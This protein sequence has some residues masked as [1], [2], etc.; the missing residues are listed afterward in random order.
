MKKIKINIYHIISNTFNFR[1]VTNREEYWT[2]LLFYLLIKF[3]MAII[4]GMISRYQIVYQ[5]YPLRGAY[6]TDKYGDYFLIL[7]LPIIA[8][9]VRRIRD[10]G[11]NPWLS[12]VPFLNLLII[13]KPSKIT[14]ER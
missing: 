12:I 10:A 6:Y 14:I 1:G 4:F 5:D 8:A 9:T 7:L 3:F 11:Y 2:Y 13:L